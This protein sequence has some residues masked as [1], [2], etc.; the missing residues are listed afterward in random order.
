MS[1][2]IPPYRYYKWVVYPRGTFSWSY[3]QVADFKFYLNGV[4]QTTF[5][6][7]TN[8]GGSNPG[9]QGP[10]N[11]QDN[12]V[13]TSWFDYNGWSQNPSTL[14]FTFPTALKFNG[15]SWWTACDTEYVSYRQPTFWYLYG[16]SDNVTYRL[17]HSAWLPYNTP[18]VNYDMAYQVLNFYGPP[19]LTTTTASSITDTSAIAGGQITGQGVDSIIV[20][21]ICWST[22]PG[23]TVAL[24][25][26]TTRDGFGVGPFTETITGLL[27]NTTYYYRAY[28]TNTRT[29]SYGSEKSFTTTSGSAIL[30]TAAISG[31]TETEAQSGGTIT[32]L[33]GSN[34]TE[35]G[36]VYSETQ[37]PTT[38]SGIV[39]STSGTVSIVPFSYTSSLG[40]LT[41]GKTYYVRAYAINSSGVRYGQE[42]K[43][44]TK[45]TPNTSVEGVISDPPI[46]DIPYYDPTISARVT[47]AFY[48]SV[49]SD[50]ISM[51]AVVWSDV[52]TTPTLSDNVR[53]I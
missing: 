31:I 9:S 8:P 23:P 43:F 6:T 45:D 11:L 40:S 3:I 33:G 7:V 42:I 52:N 51:R 2:Q 25:T 39:V 38:T 36:I 53:Y 17:L 22:S 44:M 47:S 35:Y 41:Y 13:T 5:A 49:I 18:V 1:Q 15:Y 4:L 19:V 37:N 16:S 24:K 30:Q 10:Q 32:V 27:P 28:A 50:P 34:V 29:T 12:I 20:Y 14:I 46:V 21:G 48:K 26:K